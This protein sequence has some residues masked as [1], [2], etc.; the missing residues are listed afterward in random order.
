MHIIQLTQAMSEGGQRERMWLHM[1]F[2]TQMV[3]Q[4]THISR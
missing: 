2:H 1:R 3:P 4:V